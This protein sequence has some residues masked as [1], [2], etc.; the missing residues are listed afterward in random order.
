MIQRNMMARRRLAFLLCNV[1]AYIELIFRAWW[2][3]QSL[4]ARFFA[5]H[6]LR[7]EAARLAWRMGESGWRA[8]PE[9]GRPSVA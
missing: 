6:E 8:R 7:A 1:K 5:G 3:M 9:A 4:V 2:L